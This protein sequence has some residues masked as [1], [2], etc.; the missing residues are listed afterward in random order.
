MHPRHEFKPSR[1]FR[2]SVSYSVLGGDVSRRF[3]EREYRKDRLS[4][5]ARSQVERAH[6]DPFSSSLPP[7]TSFHP[8]SAIPPPLLPPTLTVIHTTTRTPSALPTH[9][10][11]LAAVNDATH[12][13]S[14]YHHH[15][16]RGRKRVK[17]RSPRPSSC[18]RYGFINPRG[19]VSCY[20]PHSPAPA[21]NQTRSLS[22]I[23]PRQRQ[24]R[25]SPRMTRT[26]P[27]LARPTRSPNPPFAPP[28]PP[29]H[30]L[31]PTPA[32]TNTSYSTSPIEPSHSVR[33]L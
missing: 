24:P 4:S 27:P 8:V 12:T 19:R 15:F 9:N 14:Y 21:S 25:C 29:P 16:W 2:T 20:R 33:Y 22:S 31:Q 30:P 1:A 3:R 28:P 17:P 5:Y 13:E 32:P 23:P 6:V 11:T 26:Y 10:L 18:Y 7:L